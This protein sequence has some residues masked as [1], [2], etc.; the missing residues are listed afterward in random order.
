M[1]S[2]AASRAAAALVCAVA[3]AVAICAAAAA[4][5]AHQVARTISGTGGA[6]HIRFTV[7]PGVEECVLQPLAPARILDIDYL[8]RAL[9][10][11]RRRR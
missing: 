5:Q 10:R 3:A 7:A 8:V 1:A 4:A 2:R 11:W 9:R 6:V